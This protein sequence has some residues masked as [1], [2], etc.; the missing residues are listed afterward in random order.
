MPHSNS[1]N[2]HLLA[3]L[4]ELTCDVA[5]GEAI[6]VDYGPMYGYRRHGFRRRKDVRKDGGQLLTQLGEG[7]ASLWEL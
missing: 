7:L 1:S 4:A 5:A 6:T 2:L 3:A